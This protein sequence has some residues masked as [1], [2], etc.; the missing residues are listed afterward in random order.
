MPYCTRD[1]HWGSETHEYDNGDGTTNKVYHQG[2]ANVQSV[3]CKQ[4]PMGMWSV[5]FAH[6]SG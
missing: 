2:F 4:G 1:I 6:L 3:S 5:W